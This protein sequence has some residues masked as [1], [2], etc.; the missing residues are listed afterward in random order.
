MLAVDAEDAIL[1]DS[2]APYSLVPS[3]LPQLLAVGDISDIGGELNT[4]S[5]F[6]DGV[7]ANGI[8]VCCGCIESTGCIIGGVENVEHSVVMTYTGNKS[9]SEMQLGVWVGPKLSGLNNT[10]NDVHKYKLPPP[11]EVSQ[12]S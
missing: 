10:E 3:M 11:F 5:G 9:C 7:V 6:L 4:S 8:L 2:S 1:E 12:L